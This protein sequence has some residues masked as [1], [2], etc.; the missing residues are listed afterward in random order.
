MTARQ[1]TPPP[2]DEAAR[3]ASIG[4]RFMAEKEAHAS[5]VATAREQAG[6][7]KRAREAEYAH[8]HAN[9][10][11]QVVVDD[12][13]NSVVGRMVPDQ[14]KWGQRRQWFCGRRRR[15]LFSAR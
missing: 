4:A 11:G 5:A 3:A 2:S 10:H 8:A 14:P 1:A 12:R 13:G 6:G 9:A 15:R 7:G